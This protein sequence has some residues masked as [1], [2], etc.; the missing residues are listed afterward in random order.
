MVSG[1]SGGLAVWGFR[2]LATDGWSHVDDR[3][4]SVPYYNKGM[5]NS[6][7]IWIQ[8]LGSSAVSLPHS[9]QIAQAA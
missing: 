3:L 8:E 2:W 5:C 9:A 6:K 7:S 4:P 1:F